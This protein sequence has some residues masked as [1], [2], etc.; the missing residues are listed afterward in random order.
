MPLP[1]HSNPSS[2]GH[3]LCRRPVLRAPIVGF[4]PYPLVAHLMNMGTV[5]DHFP[6]NSNQ[7]K[8][9]STTIVL[10]SRVPTMIDKLDRLTPHG[11]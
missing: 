1:K 6:N 8:G 9:Y 3:Q 4:R 7:N 2:F 5:D 10:D 11:Q